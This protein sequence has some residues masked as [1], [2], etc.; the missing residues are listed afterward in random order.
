MLF[1]VPNWNFLEQI[2]HVTS[3]LPPHVTLLG[4]EH[5][6]SDVSLSVLVAILQSGAES[7]PHY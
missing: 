3:A 5:A 4:N 7:P 1:F 2:L 6:P